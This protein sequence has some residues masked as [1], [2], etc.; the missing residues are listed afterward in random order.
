[1]RPL[2]PPVAVARD[3]PQEVQRLDQEPAAGAQRPRDPAEDS[4]VVRV[5][6]EVAERG[7]EVDRGVEL[8]LVVELAHVSLREVGGEAFCRGGG[9]RVLERAWAEVEAG[10]AEA[11]AGELERVPAVSAVEVENACAL[12]EFEH[13]EGELDLALGSLV[14][15]V[16]SDLVEIGALEEPVVPVPRGLRHEVRAAS[17]ATISASTEVSAGTSPRRAWARS[18]ASSA[19]SRA[20]S[21]PRERT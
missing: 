2:P 10:D 4:V 8:L 1:M 17:P 15:D 14:R 21:G 18:A 7:E 13:A 6:L 12:L 9:A 20:P 11:A 16:Q 5:V 3:E 19:S